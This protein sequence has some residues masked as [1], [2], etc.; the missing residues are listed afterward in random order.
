ML[1]ERGYTV[2]EA[3]HGAEAIEI[4]DRH[5]GPVDLLLTDLVMPRMGGIELA[6]RLAEQRPELK[7]IFMSGYTDRVARDGLLTRDAPYLQKPVAM[8][9]VAERVREV[10]D[11]APVSSGRS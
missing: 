11:G 9:A 7:V 4:A 3:R 1:Q 6:Q 8:D 10:L 5:P 2:L